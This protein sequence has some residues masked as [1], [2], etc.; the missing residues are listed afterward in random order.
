MFRQ[1]ANFDTVRPLDR[2]SSALTSP[3][4]INWNWGRTN[5]KLEDDFESKNESYSLIQIF[6]SNHDQANYYV[7]GAIGK[8]R[9]S[10]RLVIVHM[11]QFNF[12]FIFLFCEQIPL[13]S[14]SNKGWVQ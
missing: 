14:C 9:S 13:V 11:H 12:R 5:I 7:G 4:D 1:L 10:S 2:E 6:A 8:N 3:G